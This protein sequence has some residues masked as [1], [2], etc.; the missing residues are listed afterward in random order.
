MDDAASE[1]ETIP[2]G[3]P[4]T[5]DAFGEMLRDHHDGENTYEIVE[6]DD[7]WVG[8]SAGGDLYFSEFEEWP[9]L[10]RRTMEYVEGRVLDVGCGAGR[11]A[12]YL[13]EQ[14]HDVTGID[15]SPG[16]VEVARDR[17]V[18]DVRRVDVADVTDEFDPE[19]FD[20]VVMLGN[21]FGLA[22]TAERAPG[23]LD[24][25]A[26]VATDDA[27]LVAQSRDPTATDDEHHRT[28]HEFNRERGRLPGAL[29]MRV[30]Y[31]RLATPWYDYLM[32]APDTMAD[33]VSET[34]WEL[35]ETVEP[36]E[37]ETATGGDYVG[38]LHIED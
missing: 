2:P 13:R 16:A 5:G 34:P 27:T 29:R 7:G 6:R 12:C 18:E 19:T 23:I 31:G 24:A 1:P 15:L 32:A 22:G 8:P 11:H 21:N 25:L 36:D 37:G 33:L 20:S 4:E 3:E 30:R 26:T 35:A 38:I 28:Y 9:E 14:G 17:G 10:E